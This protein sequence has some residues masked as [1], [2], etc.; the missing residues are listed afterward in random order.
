L[1]EPAGRRAELV[2]LLKRFSE[3]MRQRFHSIA[4]AH[5]LTP[6]L[7]ALLR[8]L[9]EP[10]SMSAAAEQMACDASYVTGMADRLE[11]LGYVERHPDPVDRR[12]KQLVSTPEG[13]RVRDA[14]HGAMSLGAGI[15]PELDDGD[16]DHLIRI[17]GK[18]VDPQD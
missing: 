11:A 15:F 4:N 2:E 3:Q 17:L 5:G 13:V 16:V 10:M 1:H 12:V 9:H 8:L 7:F 18:I 14:V 6:P